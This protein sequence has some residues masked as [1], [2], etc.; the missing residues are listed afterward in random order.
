M[1]P[2]IPGSALQGEMDAGQY[3][4]IYGG[5]SHCNIAKL[6]PDFTGFTPFEATFKEITPDPRISRVSK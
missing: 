3:Y 5:W 1:L 4:M 6:K 2:K